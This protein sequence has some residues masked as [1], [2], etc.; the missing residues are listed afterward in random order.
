MKKK[1]IR[2]A[3]IISNPLGWG[4]N[5]IYGGGEVVTCEIINRIKKID[6]TVIT[7]STIPPL[8]S[9]VEKKIIKIR[10][11]TNVLSFLEF[12]FKCLLYL[13]KNQSKFDILYASTTNISEILP[14]L[15]AGKILRKKIITKYHL[16]I[17]KKSKKNIYT[18]IFNNLNQEGIS[19]NSLFIKWTSITATLYIL[20]F[21]NAI[22]C[23]SHDSLVEIKA[24]F[25]KNKLFLIQNGIDIEKLSNYRTNKK[26][27]DICYLARL[28]KYKG[29]YEFVDI[30]KNLNL[31][32]VIIGSGSEINMLNKTIGNEN[33]KNITILGH[34]KDKRFAYLAKSKFLL[35]LSKSMEGFGL[36]IAEALAVGTEVICIQSSVLKKVYGNIPEVRF[37]DTKMEIEKIL[38]TR[39]E[40]LEQRYEKTDNREAKKNTENRKR[41]T[42]QNL[43]P[44]DI[45]KTVQLE[46]KYINEVFNKK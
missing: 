46:V 41:I 9:K 20:K 11:Y 18:S 29:I 45:R 12:S 14:V 30:A 31:K 23:V 43:H 2:V 6:Y 5:K 44:F 21:Y 4:K 33:I 26:I 28:E 16:T 24:Y 3:M 22:F 10:N 17:Y 32:A 36:T 13:I 34:L 37:V 1:K 35:S 25:P 39:Y 42:V 27:Y 19:G 38:E 7:P 40:K 8:N 15:V